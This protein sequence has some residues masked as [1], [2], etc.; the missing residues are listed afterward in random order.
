MGRI[1]MERSWPRDQTTMGGRAWRELGVFLALAAG[2]LIVA[3]LVHLIT[4]I[5]FEWRPTFASALMHIGVQ[6]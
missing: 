4:R 1:G 5:A 2:A 3:G 6:P